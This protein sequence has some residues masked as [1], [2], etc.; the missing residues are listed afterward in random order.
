VT[1]YTISADFPTRNSL[2]P[3]KAGFDAF[4]MKMNASSPVPEYSTYLGGALTDIALGLAV[5]G[6]GSVVVAGYTNSV[7]FPLERPV[8]SASRGFDAFVARLDPSGSRLVYSTYLGGSGDDFGYGVALDQSGAAYVAGGTASADFPTANGFQAASGGGSLD[9]FVTKLDAAGAS[10]VYSSYLG[11]GGADQCV[12]GVA[13]DASG[14]AYVTGNTDSADFPVV[15][16]IQAYFGSGDDLFVA[17][18]AASGSSLAYSTYLGGEDDDTGLAIAVDAAGSAY[19]AGSAK[20]EDA[21][22]ATA[23]RHGAESDAFVRK[24]AADGSSVVYAFSIDTLD[25]EVAQ[26]IAVDAA[27]NAYVVGYSDSPEFP[28][29]DPVQIPIPGGQD[30]FL[31]KIDAAGTSAVFSTKLGGTVQDVATGV[32]IGPDGSVF[33]VGTTASVDFPAKAEFATSA[34]GFDDGFVVRID[35]GAGP[36]PPAVTKV[37]AARSGRSFKV[38][39]RGSGFQP[40]A[41]VFIGDDEEPWQPATVKGAKI[42]LAGGA[43]LEARFPENTR[44]RIRIV[45]PDGGAAFTLLAR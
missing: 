20:E 38:T 31:M 4:V 22:K 23:P 33:V 8:V 12:G 11:G 17:K 1:G 42:K 39:I 15:R 30:A 16:P 35:P 40:G 14:A 32:A 24:L 5:G 26:G 6:D 43:A 18:V 9:G 25:E 34:R 44:V 7:D 13:V 2:A 27:G 29:K 45:N 19:V 37:K 28:T 3:Y 36:L 41:T 10:L 21:P